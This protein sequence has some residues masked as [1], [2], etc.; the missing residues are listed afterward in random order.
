M[1]RVGPLEE[2]LEPRPLGVAWGEAPPEDL[3]AEGGDWPPSAT[4]HTEPRGGA[5]PGQPVGLHAGGWRG[6][7]MSAGCA[8]RG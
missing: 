1:V 7:E 8:K 3:R 5:S 2:E 4:A 6:L